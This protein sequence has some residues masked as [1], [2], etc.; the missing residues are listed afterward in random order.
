MTSYAFTVA[1]QNGEYVAT[2]HETL[3]LSNGS[4]VIKS[5]QNHNDDGT[6][7]NQSNRQV[8]GQSSGIP[9]ARNSMRNHIPRNVCSGESLGIY[10]ESL[11]ISRESISLAPR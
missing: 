6:L 8:T 11:G 10:M 3:L 5:I 7:S 9:T 2:A 1:V 4:E